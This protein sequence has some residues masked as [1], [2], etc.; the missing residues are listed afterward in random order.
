[1]EFV[2]EHDNLRRQGKETPKDISQTLTP[3]NNRKNSE[4]YMNEV[5]QLKNIFG[6][7]PFIV[8]GIC[9]GQS[10]GKSLISL[11]FQRHLQNT[12]I[13]SEK[14]FFVG[15]KE[16]RKSAVDEK[17]S[18]LT[19]NDDDYSINR[20]QRLADI[21]NIR[22]FDWDNF[23]SCLKSFKEGKPTLFPTWDKEKGVQ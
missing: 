10:C 19:M 21:N 8:I 16:R 12:V 6:D 2:D 3:S 20:K 14:D 13:I 1:M 7:K 4:S 22:N 18:V 9:G 17:V 5:Q 23:T 15:N 11:Y